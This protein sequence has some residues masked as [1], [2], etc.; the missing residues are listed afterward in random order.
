MAIRTTHLFAVGS[1]LC[2]ALLTGCVTQSKYDALEATN[3]QL[4]D[5]NTQLQQDVAVAQSHAQAA[6]NQ[7]EMKSAHV[8][9]LQG[10]LKYTIESD[11]MFEPGGFEISEAG[12]RALASTA[13]KLAADQQTRIVVNGYTDNTPIGDKLEKEGVNSNEVLSQKRADAVRDFLISQ[14]VRPD[15]ITAVGRGESL[16]VSTNDTA[17]GRSKN[18]RVELSLGG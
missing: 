8:S 3:M 6:R 9:R 5:E 17:E 13:Q 11:L 1:L 16:P 12:K 4:Q 2:G 7:T 10:A 15:M 14:G 18:R